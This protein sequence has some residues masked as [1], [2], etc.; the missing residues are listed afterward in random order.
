LELH[1]WKDWV[2]LSP[3]SAMQLEELYCCSA[4]ML[5]EI[6]QPGC[7]HALV[8]IAMPMNGGGLRAGEVP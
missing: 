1:D 6:L 2:D 5:L 3:L 8:K 4:I 7:L